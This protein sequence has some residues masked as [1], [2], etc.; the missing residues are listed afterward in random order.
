MLVTAY[1][2]RSGTGRQK[3]FSYGERNGHNGGNNAIYAGKYVYKVQ[4][5]EI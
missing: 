3:S 2:G 5:M 1:K 4:N